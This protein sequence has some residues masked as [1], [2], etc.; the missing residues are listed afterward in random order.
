MA[1]ST[2]Y[3]ARDHARA[4]EGAR[5]EAMPVVPAGDWPAPPCEAGPPGVGRDRGGRQ[6]HPPGARPRHRAAPDRPARRRLRAPAAVPRRPPLG[7]AQRRR[8]RQGPVARPTS[9]TGTAAPV[10]PGPGA[11]HAS[12]PTPP[13]RHDALC[14]T[15]TLRTQH[16]ALRRRHARSPRPPPAASCS[17]W[18][19]PSTASDRRDLPPSRLLLPG[20]AGR[21]RR[22]ARLRWLGRPRRQR[23]AA[24]RAGRCIVLVAN[25]AAPA[26]PA[27]GV[28]LHPAGG[29]RLAR[30]RRPRPATRCGTPR[31]RAAAPSSTP[32]TT[33]PR[34]GSHDHAAPLTRDVVRPSSRPAPPGRPSSRRR[35]R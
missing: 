28:H 19:P 30:P 22:H 29:A 23:D 26:G 27:P 24:R 18:P 21:E 7:A 4:Q 25:I 31:P 34:G 33:S 17:R 6:L 12:S 15:S 35:R 10:R 2:T 11:G 9:A 5:A 13:A 32:P 16:R 1:T 20:R 8:H 14:G 3:G